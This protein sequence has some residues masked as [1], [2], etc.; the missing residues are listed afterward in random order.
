SSQELPGMFPLFYFYHHPHHQDLHSFP[1]RRSSDLMRRLAALGALVF[2]SGCASLEYYAQA[3]GGH[4]EVIRLA[5]PIEERL[6]EPDTP[7]DRKSTRLNSSHVENSYAVFCLKKKKRRDQH[8]K[9]R[10]ALACIQSNRCRISHRNPEASII[11]HCPTIN[12][13][14]DIDRTE[15]NCGNAANST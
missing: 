2:V 12:V 4:L 10:Q 11:D 5:V 9:H 3:L 1:T 8:Q 6:R 15:E 13:L 7:E 14:I